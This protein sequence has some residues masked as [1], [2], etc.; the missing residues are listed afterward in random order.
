MVLWSATTDMASLVS[1]EETINSA[2]GMVEQAGKH[3]SSY[4]NHDQGV[5][6][7]SRQTGKQCLIRK[8]GNNES[9]PANP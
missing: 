3:R 6:S 4:I 5:G 1:A 9:I 8:D 7:P 2:D